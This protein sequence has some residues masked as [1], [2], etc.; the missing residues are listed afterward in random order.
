MAFKLN[1]AHLKS[2]DP[3]K[4]AQF[5][6][7]NLGAK[8]GQCARGKGAGDGLGQLKNPDPLKGQIH[9]HRSRGGPGKHVRRP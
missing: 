3:E 7:D 2:P 8:I 9:G 4:T 6:V 1:H 5:Y